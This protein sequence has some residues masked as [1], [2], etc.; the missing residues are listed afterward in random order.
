M[1]STEVE[2]H[3]RELDHSHSEDMSEVNVFMLSSASSSPCSLG[4]LQQENC[5]GLGGWVLTPTVL[6][7]DVLVTGP[8][9]SVRATENEG[10]NTGLY[11][12]A[13][14]TCCRRL[15][16]DVPPSPAN[17]MKL[18]NFYFLLHEHDTRHTSVRRSISV[19][20]T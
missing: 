5:G 8:E 18:S 17:K 10:K 9:K 12:I 16:T 4:F 19:M 14:L 3:P 7:A 2:R 13:I 1:F 15:G 11:R 20:L 6:C